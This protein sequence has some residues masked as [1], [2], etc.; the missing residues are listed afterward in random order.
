MKPEPLKGKLKAIGNI[1]LEMELNHKHTLF[2][3]DEDILSAVEWAKLKAIKLIL[4]KN[5]NLNGRIVI[6]IEDLNK[7]FPDLEK[8]KGKRK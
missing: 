1:H 3:R 7:A 6:T 5:P 8:V 2:A 4:P